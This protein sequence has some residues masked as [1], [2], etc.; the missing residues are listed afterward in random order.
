MANLRGPEV[1]G[2]TAKSPVEGGLELDCTLET[3]AGTYKH[4]QCL[5]PPPTPIK[6]ESGL[7][8]GDGVDPVKA[9]QV[10]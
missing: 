2:G 3:P 10:K 5:G 4:Y 1:E 9:S 6:S 7:R 8:K